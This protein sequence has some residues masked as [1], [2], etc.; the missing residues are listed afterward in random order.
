MAFSCWYHEKKGLVAV[1]TEGHG[2]KTNAKGG[3][4]SALKLVFCLFAFRQ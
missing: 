2:L 3:I 4:V 1:S